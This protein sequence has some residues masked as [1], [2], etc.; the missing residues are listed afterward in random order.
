[1]R[2]LRRR[3]TGS[4][5]RPIA[6]LAAALFTITLAP[7]ALA[8]GQSG[9]QDWTWTLYANTAPIV[10]AQEIP[11]TPRL[12]TT[13]ECE[14]GQ[15]KLTLYDVPA[16]PDGPVTLKSERQTATTEARTQAHSSPNRLSS[17]I[18]VDH[19]VFLAFQANG[20]LDLVAGEQSISVRV[21]AAHIAKLRRFAEA[22]AA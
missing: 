17:V 10:L 3:Q 5:C 7:A 16:I 22:C 2:D 8:Y 14:R 1:M 11:D 6:G 20:Q 19:P 12:K 15:V 9:A 21:E 4:R 18:A 13:L